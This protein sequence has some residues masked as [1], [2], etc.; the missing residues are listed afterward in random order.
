MPNNAASSMQ[1][2]WAGLENAGMRGV[3]ATPPRLHLV[4][5]LEGRICCWRT[6]QWLFIYI[7][8]PNQVQDVL[9]YKL[10]L[11]TN[12]LVTQQ[13]RVVAKRGLMV[14]HAGLRKMILMLT[15]HLPPV[16]CTRLMDACTVTP[17]PTPFQKGTK[18]SGTLINEIASIRLQLFG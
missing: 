12:M 16:E 14:K 13:C 18:D 9:P 6:V 15:P 17:S 3:V 5:C 4:Q 10:P 8:I 2:T 7:E 1:H 11:P